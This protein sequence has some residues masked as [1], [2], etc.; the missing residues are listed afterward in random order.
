[1]GLGK[2]QL[3]YVRL[4]LTYPAIV[5]VGSL[6]FSVRSLASEGSDSAAQ[7]V[8]CID[9]SSQGHALLQK[10][11]VRKRR[12][13]S[14]LPL[15]E[16]PVDAS[17]L[18]VPLST[19]YQQ[20]GLSSDK[21]PLRPEV[22]VDYPISFLNHV[23]GND[24]VITITLER[25][26][27]RFEFSAGQLAAGGVLATSFAA[28]DGYIADDSQLSR[29]CLLNTTSEAHMTCG[30]RPGLTFGCRHKAEQAIAESHR[31][32]LTAASLRK[33]SWTAILEDDVVLV[34][35]VQWDSNFR[36]AWS[37][38]MRM[39]PDTQIV[40]LQWCSV[41]PHPDYTES[42]PFAQVGNFILS[43]WTFNQ[44]AQCTGGYMV[45][46]DVLPEI[47]SFFPCCNPVD[48]CFYYK[49]QNSKVGIEG[50]VINMAVRDS[51]QVIEDAT[52]DEHWFGQH[53]VMYQARGQLKSDKDTE[54]TVMAAAGAVR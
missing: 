32:A 52:N 1:M 54:I 29:G 38:L 50:K 36:S 34:D 9:P 11:I 43:V 51:R 25:K 22:P 20:T 13:G 10:E 31:R 7:A 33:S 12:K 45:R 18:T 28:T 26:P 6:A 46:K 21:H 17:S 3:T 5:L 15:I 24:G 42:S 30:A 37:E 48:N 23:V 39:K 47:L 4:Q 19:Y 2:I 14:A 41:L 16:Q 8:Q 40:R 35:P 53:G 27:E 49:L 44:S